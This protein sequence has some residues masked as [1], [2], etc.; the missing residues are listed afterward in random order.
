MTDERLA[1][2]SLIRTVIGGAIAGVAASAAVN[3]FQALLALAHDGSDEGEPATVKAADALS[4][5]VTGD[6]IAEP[7]RELAGRAVHYVTGVG[8]GV[9]YTVMSRHLPTVRAGWGT[10]YGLAAAA[11]LDEGLV[12]AL[13][14]GPTPQDTPPATHAYSAV[15]HS[16]FGLALETAT[17]VL[18]G[19]AGE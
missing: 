1:P 9:L 6:P 10:I 11:V 19:P 5:A 12:P 18:V 13:G 7:N 3:G 16:A 2:P 14:L 4:E 17:W 8:L 15:S